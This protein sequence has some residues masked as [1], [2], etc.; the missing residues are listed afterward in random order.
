MDIARPDLARYRLDARLYAEYDDGGLHEY[1]HG[2]EWA[3]HLRNLGL[4]GILYPSRHHTASR[5]LA[6]FER[7][8]ATLTHDSLGALWDHA[9]V[10][11]VLESVFDWGID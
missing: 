10:L 1:R 9:E 6:L 2:P 3:D 4:D 11:E 7:E 5:C 8:T